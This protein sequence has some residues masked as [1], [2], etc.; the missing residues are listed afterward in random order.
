LDQ[1]LHVKLISAGL[2]QNW[3]VSWQIYMVIDG[4]NP[5][6]YM[7]ALPR[8]RRLASNKGFCESE[9]IC[10]LHQ[11]RDGFLFPYVKPQIPLIG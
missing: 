2:E 4:N 6:I 11:I 7:L 3:G 1:K 9:R 8:T 5:E 10:E